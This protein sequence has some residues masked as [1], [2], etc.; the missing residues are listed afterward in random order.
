M[1]GA[2]TATRA[3]NHNSLVVTHG[4]ECKVFGLLFSELHG[5]DLKGAHSNP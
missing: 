2:V 5:D 4:D 1:F 3:Q